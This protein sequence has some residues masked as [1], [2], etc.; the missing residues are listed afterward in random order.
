VSK[1]KI[2][3][4]K[5]RIGLQLKDVLVNRHLIRFLRVDGTII[6]LPS[7][8]FPTLIKAGPECWEQI[9]I[10]GAGGSWTEIP[11]GNDIYGVCDCHWNEN[12]LSWVTSTPPERLN[13]LIAIAREAE[14][15]D[16]AIEVRDFRGR[17]DRREILVG[18]RVNEFVTRFD[19]SDGTV[20]EHPTEYWPSLKAARREWTNYNL[21]FGGYGIEF[22]NIRVVNE[23]GDVDEV[24]SK[25]IENALCFSLEGAADGY[26]EDSEIYLSPRE[27]RRKLAEAKAAETG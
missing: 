5:E 16:P 27:R 14:S 13:E 21:I 22:P 6:E 11:H 7:S 25:F 4:R 10:E 18:V 3:S 2:Y 24:E 20:R 19:Y 9:C 15:L 8:F 12:F 26:P 1:G 17:S 23:V